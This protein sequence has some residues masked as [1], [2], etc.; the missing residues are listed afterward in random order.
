M[1]AIKKPCCFVLLLLASCLY[2]LQA[3]AQTC[4][5]G[6]VPMSGNLGLPS[7]TGQ[8]WQFTLNYDVNVLKTL[9]DG[10]ETLDDDSRT[11]ITHSAFFQVGYGFTEKIAVEAFVP[12]VWQERTIRQ[13]G[14]TN[15]TATNGIGDAALLIKYR[16]AAFRNGFSELWIGAGPKFPTGASDLKDERGI[17]LIADLQPGSGAWD[18]LFLAQ[19][20]HNI[21]LR[22]T[23]GL[24]ARFAYRLTGENNEYLGSR[25]YEFGDEIQVYAGIADQVLMGNFLVD[26]S[27]AFRFRKANKDFDNHE[28]LPNTGGEWL[29][30][31]PGAS[32]N[33]TPNL[34]FQ[35]NAEFPLYA[36]LVGTQLTPTYRINAG[37]YFSLTPQKDKQY[38]LIDFEN[39]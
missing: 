22:P 14:N 11:R 7:T 27:L 13:F 5:S 33:V 35:V 30:I 2:N 15:R 38:Q 17:S 1:G 29:F 19:Y 9:K 36:K 20:S 28:V 37:F 10:Q 25:T 4:C 31:I 32:I 21:K 39:Q 18:G 24:N 26:P 34:T 23:L 16:A 3:N 12:Y 6:G 8:T